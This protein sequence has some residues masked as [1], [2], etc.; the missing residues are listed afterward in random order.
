MELKKLI[1]ECNNI[2]KS[3]TKGSVIKFLIETL[4]IHNLWINYESLEN[5]N[6]RIIL[7]KFQD[8]VS[9]SKYAHYYNG[10]ILNLTDKE[11]TISCLPPPVLHNM[12][13]K[14]L[15]YFDYDVYKIED[16]TV[17]TLYYFQDKW[18]ISTSRAYEANDY[19]WKDLKY[20]DIVN[21]LFKKYDFSW[22]MLEKNKSY[23]VCVQH[24]TWHPFT[25]NQEDTSSKLWLISVFDGQK[26]HYDEHIG[27]P[28]Q[29]KI[30]IVNL[31][32]LYSICDKSY[33]NWNNG[34]VINFGFRL[35]IK[36]APVE[37]LNAQ[38]IIQSTLLQAIEKILYRVE[39]SSDIKNYKI[40]RGYLSDIK[41]I[42]IRTVI[43]RRD[44][45]FL[46]L[47]PQYEKDLKE[48]MSK[49]GTLID[50]VSHEVPKYEDLKTREKL[51]PDNL[52]NIIITKYYEMIGINNP[53]QNYE[54]V[55]NL[56]FNTSYL[57]IYYQYL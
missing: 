18:V 15:E 24:P 39:K 2:L 5:E 47:F 16:G 55:R 4:N 35:V 46:I 19:M 34:H 57:D 43:Y 28:L 53:K 36:E 21:D 26:I 52:I 27:L 56:V 6:T 3:S 54:L 44:E 13:K 38:F 7:T 45:I 20:F 50:N 32:D 42:L 48:Y 23:T 12:S 11:M 41:Y 22:D 33:K 37:L 25:L 10:T 8:R 30:E 17:L 14:S 31:S 51:I 1:D 29:E 49:I 9:R 40:N